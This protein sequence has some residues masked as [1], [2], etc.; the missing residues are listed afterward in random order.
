MNKKI[1]NTIKQRILNLHYEPG[2][3]LSQKEL[4]A[5]MGVSQTPIREIFL[6]LEWEKLVTILPRIGIHVT[7]IDFKELKEVYRTRIVIEGELGRLAAQNISDEQLAE[8][9]KLLESCKKIKGEQVRE[10]L[11][12]LDKKFRDILFSSANC[13]TLNEISEVLY[14][15]TLRVW[16]LTF[17]ESDVMSELEMEIKEIESTIALFAKREPNAAQKLRKEI[18]IAWVDRLHKYYTRY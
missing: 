17:D 10:K 14:N 9:K 6:R 1:Y 3:S 2:Q 5:E 13:S 15:Q 7:K 8:M 11:V 4:A 16:H 12:E 18:I